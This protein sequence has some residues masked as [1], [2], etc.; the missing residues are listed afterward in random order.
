MLLSQ[1]FLTP[2]FSIAIIFSIYPCKETTMHSQKPLFHLNKNHPTALKNLHLFLNKKYH[3]A[4]FGSKGAINS[5]LKERQ[6]QATETEWFTEEIKDC[7]NNYN[8]DLAIK[9]SLVIEAALVNHP[10]FNHPL[11]NYLAHHA[12]SNDISHF[13]LNDSILNLEFFDYL[14]LAL[15]GVSDQTRAEIMTN[16]WDEAGKGEV[17]GFHT[18]LFKQLMADLNLTY[19]RED[20]TQAM[21]W[22]GL[23]GINLFSYLA[24]YPANKMHYFGLFAAT[25]MLDPLHYSQ[26]LV[27]LKRVFSQEKI[28]LSYYTEHETLDVEHANGW[29]HAVILP[30]LK[31]HPEKTHEFWLGFYLRLDSV[32]RY[33]DQ[34]LQS[35][36]HQQA[37]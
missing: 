36:I 19:N 8:C 27:G 18:N 13:I 9:S 4:L 6:F 1:I 29:L 5:D 25:E 17:D 15:I 23:A 16:L 2:S 3:A 22:Q 34:L 31:R 11:F 26:L 20:I 28:N 32:K 12:D 21:S 14:A 30:E 35:F 37:A 7:Y 33:Y 24:L 10:V